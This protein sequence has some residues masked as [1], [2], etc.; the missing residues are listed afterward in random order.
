MSNPEVRLTL[1]EAV[2]EVMGHLTGLDLQLV[3]ERDR[4]HSVT[5]Q[6]NRALRAVA[7]EQEWNYYAD[8]ENVG[9]T[10]GGVA[11]YILRSAIRPRVIGDDAVRLVD[12]VTNA[13]RALAHYLP[14]D[15][16]GKY[17]RRQGLRVSY[18]RQSLIFTRAFHPA[19]AGWDI[20]VPTMR[21]PK[22]F[23]LPAQPEDPNQPSVEVPEEVREQLVDFD[24]P[25]LVVMKAAYFYAQTDPIMQPRVQTLEANY[26]ELM[27]AL[28]ERDTRNTD[29]PYQN[30]WTL[31]IE[32]SVNGGSSYGGGR[33]LADERGFH[34][35]W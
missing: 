16:A 32:S 31:D 10:A 7:L 28:V 26:K 14:R 18:T 17:D 4:Y 2:A 20:L 22:Q 8:L 9:Q 30:D 13:V 6:L 34:A 21:E 3:P 29:S 33:P 23:R 25:D 15:A 1:D 24:Y 5:R 35:S 19:E 27:Y 11:E 12:P